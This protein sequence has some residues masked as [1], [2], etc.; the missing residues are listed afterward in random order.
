MN[1]QTLPAACFTL[2]LLSACTGGD[3]GSTLRATDISDVPAGPSPRTVVAVIDSGINVYHQFFHEGSP[4]YPAGSPPS[5]VTQDVLAEFGVLPQCVIELTRTGDF[6]ADFKLD[7]ERGEW[8][9]ASSCPVVWFK[10]TNV[11][12]RSFSPGTDIIL[13]D[14]EG[15]THGT[16]TSASVLGANPEAIVLFLEGITNGAESFAFNHPAVDF[17]STS[18]GAP[19]SLPLPGHITDSFKGT[20]AN[21]KL[22][23]GACDNSPSTCVQDGTGGPWWS[24]GIAGFE[25]TAANEPESSSSGRQPLSGNAVDFIADFTQTLP[26]C[27]ACE[28]GYDNYV[29]GTSFATPRSAGLASR[30]L[31]EARRA[32]GHLRGIVLGAGQPEAAPL[33]T[34]GAN[35]FSN[36][37]LRRAL[38][39]AAWVPGFADYD[40]AAAV[41]EFGPGLPIPPVAPWTVTGWGVLST[42]PEAGVMERALTHLGIVSGEV[43]VKDAGFCQYQTAVIESRR[44]YWDWVNVDSQT[45]L[46]PPSPD[47]FI[48]CN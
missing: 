25:E 47:P 9:K 18:Y 2:L 41:L 23:F 24:I 15:D 27:K 35:P 17:I 16:G 22:H 46:A 31:L 5:A 48:P 37:E 38:E 29:G 12:A 6:A 21:G 3:A 19:G 39:V 7:V 42:L 44:A 10:G 30:I 36:W 45:F 43:P 8:L 28:D 1:H 34:T 20:Y 14:D 40:P 4:I 11:L 32:N 13:P 33:M 26:Y